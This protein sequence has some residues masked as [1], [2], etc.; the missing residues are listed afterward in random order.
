M[1]AA[2][3]CARTAFLANYYSTLTYPKYLSQNPARPTAP[4]F[5][6]KKTPLSARPIWLATPPFGE[7]SDP[8]S[9]VSCWNFRDE[10]AALKMMF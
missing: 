5:R 3:Q 7:R 2:A 10:C 6:N 9:V 4:V 8:W 1:E